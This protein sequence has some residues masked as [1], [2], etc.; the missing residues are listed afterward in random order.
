MEAHY[1]GELG[2]QKWYYLA[3]YIGALVVSNIPTYIKTPE[4]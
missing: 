4:R 3:L 2:L 1:Q